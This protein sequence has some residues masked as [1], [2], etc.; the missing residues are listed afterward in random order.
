MERLY[1]PHDET[2]RKRLQSIDST[3]ILAG[4]LGRVRKEALDKVRAAWGN[5]Q[6][7]WMERSEDSAKAVANG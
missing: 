3:V 6:I 5:A 1:S 4:A 2:L 7:V